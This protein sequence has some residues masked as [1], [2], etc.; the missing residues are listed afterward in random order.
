M[1][2]HNKLQIAKLYEK[3]DVKGQ[4]AFDKADLLRAEGLRR[5]HDKEP[6]FLPLLSVLEVPDLRDARKLYP[7]PETELAMTATG[8][9]FVS[10][11]Q[12]CIVIQII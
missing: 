1:K 9:R 7:V 12:S 4:G 10:Q 6:V 3:L 2:G 5:A 8:E 11:T